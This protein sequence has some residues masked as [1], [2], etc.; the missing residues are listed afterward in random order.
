MPIR[1]RYSAALAAGIFIL[2][3]G[4]P[5]IA[6]EGLYLKG[7][8]GISLPED[9]SLESGGASVDAE[10]DRGW[11]AGIG[12]GCPPIA[13]MAHAERALRVGVRRLHARRRAVLGGRTA[14]EHHDKAPRWYA[15]LT[16]EEVYED[17]LRRRR[18][19]LRDTTGK[20]ARRRAERQAILET[21]QDHQVITVTRGAA[22]PTAI[23]GEAVW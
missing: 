22:S 12:A 15:R 16:R 19:A 2:A 9:S 1:K 7:E 3:L 10:L 23:K 18:E 13:S 14:L 5:A 21:L 20:R 4:A 11:T 6:Q 17:A 8:G